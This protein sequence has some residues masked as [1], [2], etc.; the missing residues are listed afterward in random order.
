MFGDLMNYLIIIGKTLLFY[1]LL[2]IFMRI[3]GKREVGELG[4]FDIIVFFIISELFSISISN[5]KISVFMSI[6]PIMVIVLLQIL[7][8]KL[9]LKSTKFREL[10]DGKPSLIIVNGKIDLV[11]LKKQRY[12]I[13]DLL[14]QLRDKNID[15]PSVIKYAILESNGKLS[16]FKEEDMLTLYPLPIIKNG[17]IDEK[18]LKILNINRNKLIKKL[19]SLGYDD[20]SKIE[21][22]II[23]KNRFYILDSLK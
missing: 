18:I 9:C 1:V 3:M 12:N 20:I 2:I 21:L 14:L 17:I 5:P 6:V 16:V 15:S 22:C 4:I 23:E 19:Y 7:T 13:D 8:S 11:E 10:I